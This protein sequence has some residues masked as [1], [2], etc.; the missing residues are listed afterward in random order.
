MVVIGKADKGDGTGAAGVKERRLARP[1]SRAKVV[2][3]FSRMILVPDSTC[4]VPDAG[5][6]KPPL[7]LPPMDERPRDM[8]LASGATGKTSAAGGMGSPNGVR[9]RT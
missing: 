2:D 4:I 8:T 1:G 5:P 3:V 7:R 6:E 9:R